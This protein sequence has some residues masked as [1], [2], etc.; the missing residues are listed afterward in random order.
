[1]ESKITSDYSI[2]LSRGGW[3]V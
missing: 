1:V 2:Y 3:K